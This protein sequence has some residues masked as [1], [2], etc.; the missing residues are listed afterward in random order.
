M[1]QPAAAYVAWVLINQPAQLGG[2]AGRKTRFFSLGV[3]RAS[4][5]KAIRSTLEL[6]PLQKYPENWENREERMRL[7]ARAGKTADKDSPA[8]PSIRSV[9]L[10]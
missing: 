7:G 3:C 6:L 10:L 8:T 5:A 1:R 2:P 9:I 4:P